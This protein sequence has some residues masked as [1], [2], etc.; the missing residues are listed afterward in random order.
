MQALATE[1]GPVPAALIELQVERIAS[2][3][4]AFDPF[5]LPTRDL[6]R[7][8]ED[9]I[10]GWARELPRDA[11]WRIIVHAPADEARAAGA[12]GEAFRNHFAYR[13]RGAEG[14]LRELFR[15]ARL[16]LLIGGVVLS[17][18]V[19]AARAASALVADPGLA[20]VLSEGL[21]ILGWVVN[22]RPIEL[23]LY[24]WWP[25]RRRGDLFRRLA[26]TPV[27][28]LSKSPPQPS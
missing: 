8:A 17:F 13:A 3:F 16:S 15:F 28:V 1:R 6:S 14:D 11:D 7:A 22:W 21:L 18:C 5:P 23:L 4:D 24:D 2:L 25:L 12:L 27:D 19:I 9:F 26:V 10:V 20:R